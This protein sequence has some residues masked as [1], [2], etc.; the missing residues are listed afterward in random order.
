[1]TQWVGWLGP[2]LAYKPAVVVI[3]LGGNDFEGDAEQFR[4][5][6]GELVTRLRGG[7]ARVLWV[8]PLSLPYPDRTGV[9]QMWKDA[10]GDDWFRSEH[11]EYKRAKD[12]V[13]TTYINYRDWALRIWPWVVAKSRESR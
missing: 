3:S 4:S 5:A 10:V 1:M 7:G 12:R 13:H 8:H 9:R 11:L 2:V 6:I